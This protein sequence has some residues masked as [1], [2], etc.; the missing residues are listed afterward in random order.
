MITIEVKLLFMIGKSNA[1]YISEPNINSNT[2]VTNKTKNQSQMLPNTI[3]YC[4]FSHCHSS[5]IVINTEGKRLFLSVGLLFSG[6]L[7]GLSVGISRLCLVFHPSAMGV[8]VMVPT[9]SKCVDPYISCLTHIQLR[10]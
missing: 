2:S 10:L 1:K 7:Y 6:D 4:L 3:E 9:M 8:V 5:A